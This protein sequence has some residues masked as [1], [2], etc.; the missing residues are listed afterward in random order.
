MTFHWWTTASVI[1]YSFSQQDDG[2]RASFIA[3]WQSQRCALFSE[4]AVR[5]RSAAVRR[6]LEASRPGDDQVDWNREAVATFVVGAGAAFMVGA[7]LT[8]RAGN[9]SAAQRRG[10]FLSGTGFLICAA[11]AR[12]MQSYGRIGVV[13][14]LFGTITATT[15][16]YVLMKERNE[17]QSTKESKA[18]E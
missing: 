5:G 1:P 7:A 6:A 8:H 17:R 14:S 2:Q 12:W 3:S 15:G 4:S 11:S 10:L 18:R 16:M 9:F 13:C